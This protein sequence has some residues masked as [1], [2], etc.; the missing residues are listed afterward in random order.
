MEN[1]LWYVFGKFISGCIFYLIPA[2]IVWSK[3]KE[4][5]NAMLILALFINT[6]FIFIPSDPSVSFIYVV[7]WI[8]LGLIAIRTPVKDNGI[9]EEY[10]EYAEESDDTAETA[11]DVI[12]QEITGISALLHKSYVIQ[13]IFYAAVIIL[14][15]II[16]CL[17]LILVKS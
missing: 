7:L 5:R 6:L 11:N 9:D 12:E 17:L 16:A 2:M 13:N 10:E 4:V 1:V 15:V 8:I 3:D 14:L